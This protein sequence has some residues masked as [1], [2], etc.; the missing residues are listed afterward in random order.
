MT[1]LPV[2]NY[3][4]YNDELLP[5]SHFISSENEGGIYEVLRVV[6]GTPL[7]VEEHLERFYHSAGIAN[8]TIRFSTDEIR[9]FLQRLVTG[10]QVSEG[11]ILLSCKTNLKAYFIAHRYPDAEMYKRG[12]VCGIL[13]AERK[14]PNA[15]VFQTTVRESANKLIA[16]KV[17]YEVLLEDYLGRLTEGSR[18]NV[19]F[20]KNDVLIT[21]PGNEVLLGITR[22]KTISLA[23]DLNIPFREEDIFHKNLNSYEAAIITGTS[24]KILPVNKIEENSFNPQHEI[25]RMLM[26][27][28][29]ALITQYIKNN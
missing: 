4:V 26:K 14:N 7:F 22:K 12:V 13:E 16:Q 19:F 29:D 17:F 1:L 21:P 3:F 2:H 9:Q 25:V 20:V 28:Y 18:S 23:K 27:E 5:V 10:S 6:G 24:P 8:K 15:K 11:N